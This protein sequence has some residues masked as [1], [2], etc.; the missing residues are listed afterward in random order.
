MNSSSRD[1]DRGKKQYHQP[2]QFPAL[3][4]PYTDDKVNMARTKRKKKQSR[5]SG[6]PHSEASPQ[7][8]SLDHL[9]SSM[10]PPRPQGQ[11][12]TPRTPPRPPALNRV[13]GGAF[14]RSPPNGGGKQEELLKQSKEAHTRMYPAVEVRN[15]FDGFAEGGEQQQGE[16]PTG[17]DK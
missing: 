7:L 6:Y 17:K 5:D 4:D 11:A 12:V 13:V 15:R 16:A 14:S 1:V 10:T 8:I 3:F 9:A 2:G